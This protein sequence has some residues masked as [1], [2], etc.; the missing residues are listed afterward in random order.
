MTRIGS[1]PRLLQRGERLAHP[2]ARSQEMWCRPRAPAP[3]SRRTRS[4]TSSADGRPSELVTAANLSSAVEGQVQLQDVDP[5]LAE[6]AQGPTLDRP[7]D[8]VDDLRPATA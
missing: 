3:A 8:Q 4:S 1:A 5:R 7:I 2:P 6:D